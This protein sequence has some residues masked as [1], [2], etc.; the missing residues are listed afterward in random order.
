MSTDKELMFQ[1]LVELIKK[2]GF[3]SHLE[4]LQALKASKISD[5]SDRNRDAPDRVKKQILGFNRAL[6]KAIP[7]ALAA[8]A[9]AIKAFLDTLET[10]ET[11]EDLDFEAVFMKL[12]SF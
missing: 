5:I 8:D 1:I 12:D 7:S 10:G 4:T 3:K 6:D 2:G 9:L 11:R